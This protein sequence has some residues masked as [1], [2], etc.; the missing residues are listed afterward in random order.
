MDFLDFLKSNSQFFSKSRQNK[1][2]KLENKF[3]HRKIL[4]N[5]HR[6][7]NFSMR[8]QGQLLILFPKEKSR[9]I[10]KK[11]FLNKFLSHGLRPWET[12]VTWMKYFFPSDV[13]IRIIETNTISL[14]LLFFLNSSD[15]FLYRQNSFFHCLSIPVSQLLLRKF[16][17]S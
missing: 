17:F 1:E 11:A 7:N 2:K 15:C 3:G 14:S 6:K 10:Q 4:K 8:V 13:T 9:T 5:D 16:S 12:L